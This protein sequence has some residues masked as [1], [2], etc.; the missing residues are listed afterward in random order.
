MAR[1]P[2]FA[3]LWFKPCVRKEERESRN[4][5][6][7][8][9]IWP[10]GNE[11]CRNADSHVVTRLVNHNSEESQRASLELLEIIF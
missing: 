10:K 3:H 1:G 7:I 4:P 11:A 9:L 6:L 5:K 2:Q 8:H